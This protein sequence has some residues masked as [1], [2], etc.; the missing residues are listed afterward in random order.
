MTI[1]ER[2]MTAMRD[3]A[4][5]LEADPEFRPNILA[6]LEISGVDAFQDAQLVLKARIKTVPL[7]QW[8]VGRELRKRMAKTFQER[9]ISP[10]TGRMIVSLENPKSQIPNPK[11][12]TT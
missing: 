10:P 11:S 2:V 1:P 8:V 6:P 7:K 9:G 12:Q 5:A 3:A 4:A